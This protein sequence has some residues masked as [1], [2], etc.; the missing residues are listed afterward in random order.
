LPGHNSQ[1][2]SLVSA[3]HQTWR[4]GFGKKTT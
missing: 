4:R 2:A 1:D 3:G